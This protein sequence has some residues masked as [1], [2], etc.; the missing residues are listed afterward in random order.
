MPTYKAPLAD[1][2]FVLEDVLDIGQLTALP[3]YADA[4]PELIAT[5]I[6]EAARLCEEEL[7]PLNQSGDAEGCRYEHGRV[8]TPNGF[9]PVRASML[10]RMCP[11]VSSRTCAVRCNGT[12]CS[13]SK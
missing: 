3:G 1:I 10:T 2:Q 8:R 11:L 9:R 6:S 12:C 7:A 5:V 13:C 4:T